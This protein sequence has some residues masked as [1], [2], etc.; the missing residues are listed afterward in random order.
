M[1]IFK[2]FSKAR[3][4][5]PAALM[6]VTLNSFSQIKQETEDNS[7]SDIKYKQ[8]HSSNLNERQGL[9]A[10][11]LK[12]KLD[13]SVL[14]EVE[15]QREEFNPEDI[16]ADDL[17]GGMWENRYVDMYS[18]LKNAPDTFIVDLDN[19]T[20]PAAGHMTSNFGRRG[21][22][23]YHYGI[24]IKAQTGDTIYAAFDGK[25]R[26][27][28]YERSGYGY[29]LVVRH[30]NGLETVYGHL[31]KFLVEEND[32]VKSG[33]PIGLAGNTGRSFGSHLHFETRFLGKPIN[34]NFIIDFPSK[35][36]HQD[37][38]LVT[39][40]SYRKTNSSSRSVIKTA[41]DSNNYRQ[42]TAETNKFVSGEVQYHRIQKGDT[43]GAIS[44]R[45]GT[46]VSKLCTLNNMTSKTVL[47]VGKTI[48]VS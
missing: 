26:V 36:V 38:Y 34:P 5:L 17:Y 18:S 28:R 33:E 6:F 43:L 31:S 20:M 47:R 37:E 10:D 3:V 23:R 41:A 48:R 13:L 1:E 2:L 9:F 32:F 40:S 16:P 4:I 19:F 45:Y 7:R 29:Y 15:E 24:D 8:L 42:P 46:S 25:I 11:G 35:T 21:S 30:V 14:D 12:L 27:K 44:R 39:N 22:R